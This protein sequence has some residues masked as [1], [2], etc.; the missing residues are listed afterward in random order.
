MAL[1]SKEPGIL[2]VA[3]TGNGLEAVKLAESKK[4]DVVVI[5]VNLKKL[6]GI[7]AARRMRKLIASPEPVFLTTAHNE[8][9]MH[10]AFTVGA[11]AYLL[12]DIDFKELV[13]AVR[14]ASVGDYYLTGPASYEMV[15]GYINPSDEG[16]GS[17]G[18]LTQ[19]E[20]ELARLLADGH[21]T[22]EAAG[23][24]DISVKTAETHRT[25]IM[26]K[27][28]AKNVTDIV[29]FCIRNKLIEP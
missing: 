8:S 13:L 27:L 18:L 24:L 28:R 25:S 16:H 12:Q 14:K 22:K 11:R 1:L 17:I 20:N 10:E 4:P 7:T 5:N 23:F 19:R 15:T 9:R 29:K 3:D 26:R 2:I 21:S 6:D